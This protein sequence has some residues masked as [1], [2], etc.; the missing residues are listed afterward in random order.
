MKKI[1]FFLTLITLGAFGALKF[2]ESSE[3]PKSVPR[4]PELSG[5]SLSGKKYTL[6]ADF[7]SKK[8]LILFAYSQDQAD[9]LSSWVRGLDLLNS[10]I[11]WFETPVI[12]TPLRLGSFFIDGG[13]R[14]GI[15]D[16]RI[17]DRVVTLYTNREAF[18]KSLGIPFNPEGAYALVLDSSGFLVGFVSGGYDPEKG[19]QILELLRRP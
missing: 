18:S 6:P 17:R 7:H 3:D 4:F 14:D 13:M 1:L 19:K 9:Q 15:P 5:E 12:S 10:D 2:W 11:H 8:T 16:P